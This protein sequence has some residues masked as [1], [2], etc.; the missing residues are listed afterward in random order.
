[1]MRHR[2]APAPAAQRGAALMEAL[3]AMLIVAFGVLGFVGLQ[4]R[5]AVANLEGYQRA[6][7]LVL[8]NDMAQR[9]NNNR[10]DLA[11]YKAKAN[12]GDGNTVVDC[13][14]LTGANLDLCEWG[15]LLRGTAQTEGTNNLGAML[16]AV[17]CIDEANDPNE[18]LVSVVWK[19]VQS[20]KATALTC[21]TERYG[22]DNEGLRR[23][24]STLVR[25]A[26]LI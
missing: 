4:A 3:V 12:I 1:M 10:R 15:N 17:G 24:V 26:P 6:Q 5:T 9:I 20:T 13:A 22:K 21:G 7:A 8:I 14:G 25:V 19:G 2:S 16:G 23:G 18:V 11:S